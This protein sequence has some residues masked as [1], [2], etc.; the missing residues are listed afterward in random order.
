ME[1]EHNIQEKHIRKFDWLCKSLNKLLEEVRQDEP[2]A[3]YYLEEDS[4]HLMKGLSHTENGQRPLH[5]NSVASIYM[6]YSGGGAW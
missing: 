3:N 2:L 1:T 4:M 6:P 5:E